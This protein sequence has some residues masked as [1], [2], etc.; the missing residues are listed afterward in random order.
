[1]HCQ[2]SSQARFWRSIQYQTVHSLVWKELGQRSGTITR[3]QGLACLVFF[4]ARA[5]RPQFASH[6]G[7]LDAWHEAGGHRRYCYSRYRLRLLNAAAALCPPCSFEPPSSRPSPS[8]P[9]QQR[10]HPS[11]SLPYYDLGV[12]NTRL[13]PNTQR[14]RVSWAVRLG[15]DGVGLA[16][17][18]TAKLTE[19]ADR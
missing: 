8:P 7:A 5:C 17:Q 6:W 11:M 13:E 19:Q 1:M 15:W 16:H 18:A 3:S 9:A 12:S 4:L 2:K 14:E 10:Q